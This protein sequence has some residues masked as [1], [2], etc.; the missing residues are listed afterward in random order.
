MSGRND[1]LRDQ[2]AEE[3]SNRFEDPCSY[4][5]IVADAVLALPA[6][7]ATEERARVAEEARD[8]W[9][10]AARRDL[11]RALRA[12]ARVAELEGALRP[13]VE[14]LLTAEVLIDADYSVDEFNRIQ[15]VRKHAAALLPTPEAP[16]G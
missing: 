1:E 5:E 13:A 6:L 12:E 9:R 14:A 11:E 3:L 8:G 2:I 10:E 16:R 7:R 4:C 15:A